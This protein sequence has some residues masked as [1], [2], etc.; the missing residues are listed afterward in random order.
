MFILFINIIF[1]LQ[2]LTFI[3]SMIRDICSLNISYKCLVFYWTSFILY[4]Y[5]HYASLLLS[6]LFY[7][8]YVIFFRLYFPFILFLSWFIIL[9]WNNLYLILN[10]LKIYSSINSCFPS[11]FSLLQ[12]HFNIIYLIIV[13]L[14]Y[15]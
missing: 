4:S 14:S 9:F 11:D 7:S 15:N 2:F 8:S 10:S 3:I 13:V 12:L 5:F 1:I 6:L